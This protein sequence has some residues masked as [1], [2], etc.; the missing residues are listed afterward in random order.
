M[1]RAALILFCFSFIIF[2]ST[3]QEAPVIGKLID[4]ETNTPLGFVQVAIFETGNSTSPITYSDSDD[5]GNFLLKVK[6]GTYVL[7]AFFIG[8]K[9]FE[10]NPLKVEGPKDLGTLS[11][12]S[13]N[14]NLEEVVVTT[15][16]LPVRT[17]MEG[18]TI[19]PENNLANLG[20]T[21]LDIL[22]NTPSIS[23][24]EDGAIALRG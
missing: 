23:V 17:T 21:L 9:D 24:S 12:T 19:T 5:K 10:I 8:Y 11:L 1:I 20:G 13:E 3:A 16:K 18:I 4:E 7:R 15:S 6:P 2:K 14:Q 22:R